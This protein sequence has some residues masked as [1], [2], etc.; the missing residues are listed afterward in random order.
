MIAIGSNIK[1]Y[2]KQRKI[3]QEQLAKVLGVSDQAVSRWENGSTYPD[4]ELL[5]TIALYFRVTLDELMGMEAIKDESDIEDILNR[6]KEFRNRGEVVKSY[7]MLREAVK[8]YPN[9][10]ELILALVSDLQFANAEG[11]ETWHKNLLEAEGLIDRVLNECTDSEHCKKATIA[12][13]WNCIFL[14]RREEAAAIAETLPSMNDC[15][16]S[17]MKH[18]YTGEK[19]RSF[20]RDYIEDLYLDMV[21]A[22]H[23]YGDKF[24][25]DASLTN[26]ER[27]AIL[28][29]EIA[30]AELIFEGNPAFHL[31]N[32]TMVHNDIA[33]LA[34][35]DGDAELALAH[36]EAAKDA[37]IAC[38]TLPDEV[39]YTSVLMR[40]KTYRL[41][42]NAKNY[43]AT[44]REALLCSMEH[45]RFDIIRGTERFRNVEKAL[46]GE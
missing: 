28:E 30:L 8:R 7:E 31:W 43:T 20:C 24:C 29:K 27:I 34:C 37:A 33:K 25:E 5:P 9:N 11:D 36:L 10:Y 23:A 2:R 17:F 38:D 14:E 44:E 18:I 42:D 15:R 40:G 45:K 13:M 21:F 6:R 3:T 35:S 1:K 22:I 46:Q 4:I 41:K 16:E 39:P 32:I 19:L 12:K 26:R